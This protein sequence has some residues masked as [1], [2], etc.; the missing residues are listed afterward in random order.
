MSETQPVTMKQLLEAGVHFGHQ[1]QRWNPKMK[2]YIFGERN[3]IYIINLQKTVKLF[4]DAFEFVVKQAG[5][6]GSVLFVGTKKQAQ[7]IIAEEARRSGQ[8]FVTNRWLGGTLTNFKTVKGSIDRLKSLEKMATD[9]SFERLPKKEVIKLEREREKLERNLGGIK[10][11][12]RLPAVLF[13]IDPAREQIAVREANKLGITVVAVVDTNCDPEEIDFVVP[14]NDDAIRAIKLFA[15]KI[16]DACV[17]GG[18]RY[19][20]FLASRPREEKPE[21]DAPTER[22]R[23]GKIPGGPEVEVV[24]RAVTSEAEAEPAAEEAS[25][26]EAP[27]EASE[28]APTA[29]A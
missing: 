19:Q 20:E 11:M 14:G 7:E 10:D 8:Y 23:R 6:G 22:P 24:R 27:V 3:G 1:T 13:V 26:E 29:E 15:G 12:T 2:P 28:A 16:A 9:G 4:R 18:A 21:R 17:E 25:T 5:Q